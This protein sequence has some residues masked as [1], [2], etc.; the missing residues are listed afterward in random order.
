MARRPL[1]SISFPI[2][3]ASVTVPASIAMLFGWTVLF[4]RRMSE[5]SDVRG[6]LWLLIGGAV[7]LVLITSVLVMFSILLV[8]EIL[9]G[10]RQTSFIDSVTHELK[11]PLASI[12]LCLETL[13]RPEL[14]ERQ[15]GDL[16]S[17]M[18]A[19]VERLSTFID[20]V[21][22]ANRL[23]HGT[24]AHEL[25][26]VRL[27]EVLAHSRELIRM[28][29]HLPEER[30][31]LEIQGELRLHTDRTALE[32]VVKNLL[33]NA[34]KYSEPPALIHLRASSD[35]ETITIEV[36]DAGIGIAKRDLKRIFERFY[37]VPD[38]AVRARRGTGLGLFVV[39][40]TV[41]G[42]GGTVEAR[43]A[44]MGRGTSIFVRLPARM[45]GAER[46]RAA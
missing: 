16:Q 15:R 24:G 1:R 33:D 9:E 12:R 37:R 40:A 8:R 31:H 38:E 20:D 2:T 29:H 22:E 13:A 25:V 30:I 36:Q 34:V 32:T 17:M 23:E 11:S 42:L 43:S 41:R 10:R 45:R 27:E 39:A 5:S 19:D 46:A 44:G 26:E 14:S 35:G 7:S 21:L 28:R 6:E 18:L 3:L 4:Y